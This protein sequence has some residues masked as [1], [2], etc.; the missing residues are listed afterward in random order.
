MVLLLAI[1]AALLALLGYSLGIDCHSLSCGLWLRW[2]L[3]LTAAAGAQFAALCI[4]L[5]IPV[6]TLV[7]PAFSLGLLAGMFW[8]DP[9]TRKNT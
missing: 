7:S 6:L 3:C 1:L 2:L 5:T 8:G 4:Y 9:Y